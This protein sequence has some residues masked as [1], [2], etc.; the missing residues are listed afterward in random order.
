MLLCK[1]G[2]SA[3]LIRKEEK[4]NYTK[5]VRAVYKVSREK[6]IRRRRRR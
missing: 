6:T 1:N 2:K 3:I 4:R 5:E